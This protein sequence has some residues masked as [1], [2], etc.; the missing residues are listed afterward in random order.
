M[1]SNKPLL[2]LLVCGFVLGFVLFFTARLVWVYYQRA[3]FV[4]QSAQTTLMP[5]TGALTAAVSQINGEVSKETREEQTQRLTKETTLIQGE[6]IIATN[7]A[8]LVS[9][10]DQATLTLG[11]NTRVDYVNGLPDA[12]VLSQ[13]TGE[14][15]YTI[16]NKI[17]PFS[18]QSLALLIQFSNLAEVTVTTNADDETVS[19]YVTSGE[20][21]LAYSDADYNTQVEKIT[22]GQSAIFENEQ[23]TLTIE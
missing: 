18:I 1:K 10:K 4:P 21:T 20:L 9:F 23:S 13:T 19:V 6:S 7:G 15:T 17:K 12:L 8:A 2:L 14:V 16:L 3:S 22:E 5:P 11:T